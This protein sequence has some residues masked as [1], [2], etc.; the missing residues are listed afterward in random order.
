MAK[1]LIVD[2]KP[3]NRSVLATLLSYKGHHTLEASSGIEALHQMEVE[4]PELIITDI[5]MPQMDGYEFVRKV[6]ELRT[7][8]QPG[9]IF[10]SATIWRGKLKLWPAP[11]EYLELSANRANRMMC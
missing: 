5:L 11:V 10:Y 8:R 9:I 3:L 2:D 7:V 6:R 4:N 1:I